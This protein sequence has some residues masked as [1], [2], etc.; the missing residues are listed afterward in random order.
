[1]VR[2]ERIE[3]YKRV[4]IGVTFEQRCPRQTRKGDSSLPMSF[5]GK[6]STL[7]R[8]APRLG[9]HDKEILTG[10]VEAQGEGTVKPPKPETAR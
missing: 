4:Y 6:R 8:R 10:D 5:D 7:T 9:E 3:S 2:Q 1:M